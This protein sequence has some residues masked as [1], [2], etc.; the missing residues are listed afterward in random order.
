MDDA[1]PEQLVG[2]KINHCIWESQECR[3][4]WQKG[5]DSFYISHTN[6]RLKKKQIQKLLSEKFVKI[7]TNAK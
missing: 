2:V 1:P 3:G 7:N 4:G 5:G 6:E